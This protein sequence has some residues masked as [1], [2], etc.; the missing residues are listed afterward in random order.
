MVSINF[1]SGTSFEQVTDEHLE[2]VQD[3]LDEFMNGKILP[4][5]LINLLKKNNGGEPIQRNFETL[6][7]KYPIKVFYNISEDS[8]AVL[9]ESTE[10]CDMCSFFS[11]RF[12]NANLLPIAETSFG[13]VIVLNYENAPKDNP[14]VALWF[15]ECDDNGVNSHPLEPVSEDMESFLA[16]LT[17][18]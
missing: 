2:D 15:H 16:M 14:R 8:P 13:D 9:H 7:N 3:F 18:D 1:E 11:E 10:L 6:N 12:N 4:R 17:K 5:A